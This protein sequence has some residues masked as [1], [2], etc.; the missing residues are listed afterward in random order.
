[1]GIP[2]CGRPL[3]ETY[4]GMKF[5][6]I[7]HCDVLSHFTDPVAEFKMMLDRLNPGGLLIFETGNFGDVNPSYYHFMS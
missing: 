2:T 6:I 1:M 3:A 7:S 4:P 5:D